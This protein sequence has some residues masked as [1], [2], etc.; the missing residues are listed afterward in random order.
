MLPEDRKR[1]EELRTTAV[2]ETPE[3]AQLRQTTEEMLRPFGLKLGLCHKIGQYETRMQNRAISGRSTLLTLTFD[4]HGV[5][6]SNIPS[7][8]GQDQFDDTSK[9]RS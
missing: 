3:L 9:V 5:L 7:E 8:W 1:Y 2:K 4:Q 6:A